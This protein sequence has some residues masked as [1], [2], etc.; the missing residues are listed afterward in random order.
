[1]EEKKFGNNKIQHAS[2]ELDTSTCWVNGEKYFTSRFMFPDNFVDPVSLD[3]PLNGELHA[4]A[5]KDTTIMIPSSDV[6]LPE[7]GEHMLD[8]NMEVLDG[9]PMVTRALLH[10]PEFDGEGSDKS[11]QC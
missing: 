11:Q 5:N 1:M 8:G 3:T 4:D 10:L 2:D 7:I 9:N 6:P